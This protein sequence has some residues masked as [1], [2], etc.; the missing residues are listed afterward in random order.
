MVV[1]DSGA[2]LGSMLTPIGNPQNLYLYSCGN[3]AYG[4]YTFNASF[5]CNFFGIV[6]CG[7]SDFEKENMDVAFEVKNERR[8]RQYNRLWFIVSYLYLAYVLWQDCFHGNCC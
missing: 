7:F 4:L 8:K 3:P 6:M 2:N 1:T 5:Y